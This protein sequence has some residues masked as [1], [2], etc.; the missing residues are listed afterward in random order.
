MI[1][2]KSGY[3]V[4][5]FTAKN[6]VWKK[7]R[8]LAD[9]F[10]SKPEAFSAAARIG[11]ELGVEVDQEFGSLQNRPVAPSGGGFFATDGGY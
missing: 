6:G 9:G 7:T 5:L 3:D 4:V 11:R 2:V 10:A 1:A 8:V